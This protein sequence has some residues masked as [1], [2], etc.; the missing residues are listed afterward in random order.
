MAV[1]F[2]EIGRDVYIEGKHIE[3]AINEGV[4]RGYKKGYMRCSVVKDP[5]RRTNTGDN[6]PAVIYYDIVEGDKIVIH[7]APKGF[8]SENMSTIKMLKPSDGPEGV[9]KTVIEAI[10]RAGANPCP[11][12][13]VGVGIGGTMEKAALISKKALLRSVDE[14]NPD[15]YYR[16]LENE[17][18]EKI[19]NLGIGPAGLGGRITALGVNIETYPTHIAGL[20]VAVNISCHATRHKSAT[21]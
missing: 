9:K 18:L 5:L 14:R 11:P 15:P 13:I 12:V 2:V 10:S 21:I 1:I 3:D 19:N 20:P 6:T 16:D 17:L 4:R 8:G 7:V